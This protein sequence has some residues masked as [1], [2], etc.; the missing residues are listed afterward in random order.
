M[1][2]PPPRFLFLSFSE[3]HYFF[4]DKSHLSP[5]VA[6]ACKSIGAGAP[7]VDS[8]FRTANDFSDTAGADTCSA[9]T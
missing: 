7:V 9:F 5:A 2:G 8:L 4:K 3:C 1:S 6:N